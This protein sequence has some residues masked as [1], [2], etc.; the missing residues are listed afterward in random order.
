MMAMSIDQLCRRA[1]SGVDAPEALKWLTALRDCPRM[2]EWL[3]LPDDRLAD[4]E[5]IVCHEL[6]LNGKQLSERG[7]SRMRELTNAVGGAVG[8]W[9]NLV[10]DE[11]EL[12]SQVQERL[13]GPQDFDYLSSIP[14]HPWPSWR[15]SLYR[16]EASSFVCMTRL[17]VKWNPEQPLLSAIRARI[18]YIVREMRPGPPRPPVDDIPD[19]PPEPRESGWPARLARASY[20]WQVEQITSHGNHQGH[21]VGAVAHHEAVRQLGIAIEKLRTMIREFRAR[22]SA[23][24]ALTDLTV[25]LWNRVLVVQLDGIFEDLRLLEPEQADANQFIEYAGEWITNLEEL[26]TVIARNTH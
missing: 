20:E 5:R 25:P 2:A 17:P 12:E 23:T 6:W 4:L 11:D 9:R 3:E 10:R 14:Q 21:H 19:P 1:F 18:G 16:L 8:Y 7:L 13:V 15:N 24:S 26:Q 22:R